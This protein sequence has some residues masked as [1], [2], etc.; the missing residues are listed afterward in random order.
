MIL[1]IANAR[2][3]ELS[4]L[5]IFNNINIKNFLKKKLPIFLTI[6]N[7][8]D[9]KCFNE[10]FKLF[11]SNKGKYE[12]RVI[13]GNIVKNLFLSAA[14]IDQFGWKKEAVPIVHEKKSIIARLFD[15]LFN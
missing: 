15:F 3:E 13:D 10:S 12:L 1:D 8:S 6:N 9:L 11:F 7:Q 2:I 14:N 4:E 5:I